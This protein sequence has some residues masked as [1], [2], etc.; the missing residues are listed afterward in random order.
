MTESDMTGVMKNWSAQQIGSLR[1]KTVIV[2]GA[3]SGIGYFTAL[4]LGRAGA[5]VVVACRDATR[6]ETALQQ[7]RIDAPGATFSLE[8]LD[9]ANLGSVRAFA[10]RFLE[11]GD[12]LDLLVNN[13]G[14][15]AIP[16][17]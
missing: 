7:L 4:E 17:R 2:T 11:T 5:R 16:H 1:G 8:T 6:G 3:N 12:A 15:M 14:V 13:A 10:S 9:L